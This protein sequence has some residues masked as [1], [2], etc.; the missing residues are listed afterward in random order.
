[1]CR[2]KMQMSCS[3]FAKIL[4]VLVMIHKICAKRLSFLHHPCYLP[5][6][7]HHQLYR[8]RIITPHNVHHINNNINISYKSIHTPI[9]T[10]QQ[11]SIESSK[12]TP[13]WHMQRD[14][15]DDWLDDVLI[16]RFSKEACNDEQQQH[17]A[18]TSI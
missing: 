15:A 7:S 11:S 2:K 6:P 4:L 3:I 1:M 9:S 12:D 16:E 18:C 14:G 13:I 8:Q 5:S 17:A 10:S